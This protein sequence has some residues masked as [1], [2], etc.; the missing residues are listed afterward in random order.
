MIDDLRSKIDKSTDVNAKIRMQK[1]LERGDKAAKVLTH[2]LF[3]EQMVA[4]QKEFVHKTYKERQE[5]QKR[6]GTS[7]SDD[8]THKKTQKKAGTSAIDDPL[9]QFDEPVSF[10]TVSNI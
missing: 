1:T 2:L 4:L 6:A 3:M 5:A 7:S 9:A 8:A 10:P